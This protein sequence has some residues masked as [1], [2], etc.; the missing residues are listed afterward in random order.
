MNRLI[1]RVDIK[2]KPCISGFFSPLKKLLTR[3]GLIEGERAVLKFFIKSTL[4]VQ[5][6]VVKNPIPDGFETEDVEA[7]SYIKLSQS[8]VN[9][10]VFKG[11]VSLIAK[12]QG[13]TF[14]TPTFIVKTVNGNE[15]AIRACSMRISILPGMRARIKLFAKRKLLPAIKYAAVYELVT[16]IVKYF[17]K[18]IIAKYLVIN[19]FFSMSPII[20]VVIGFCVF[21]YLVTK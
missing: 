13:E 11:E 15:Y 6:I 16:E 14:Y 1:E 10:G 9:P 5:E 21:V 7:A 20:A 18:G 17:L 2:I 12:E 3:D 4:S 19:L 8:T